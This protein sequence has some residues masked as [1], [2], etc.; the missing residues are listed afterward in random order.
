AVDGQLRHAASVC[1]HRR[2][3]PRTDVAG[4]VADVMIE[5][6]AELLDVRDVRADRA[7]V[8]GADR[9]TRA[10]LGDVHDGVGVLRHALPGE[11]P[12][13]DLVDPPGALATRRALPARL[14][15]VEAGDDVE[16]LGDAR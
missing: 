1:S 3:R 5:L 9:A 10:A 2:L 14:V 6:R 16:R 8:E 13:G 7:V 4:A 12:A 15:G 11:D